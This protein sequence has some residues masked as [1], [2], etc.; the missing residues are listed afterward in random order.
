MISRHFKCIESFCVVFRVLGNVFRTFCINSNLSEVGFCFL[1]EL[2]HKADLLFRHR[3]R[4]VT[5]TCL[6]VALIDI[7]HTH[8]IL[9]SRTRQCSG[10][11]R[12]KLR[13][14]SSDEIGSFSVASHLNWECCWTLKHHR[15]WM[16]GEGKSKR[17]RPKH[18]AIDCM[19]TPTRRFDT[20]HSGCWI[21]ISLIDLLL[22]LPSLMYTRRRSW[23]H[24]VCRWWWWWWCRLCPTPLN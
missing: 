5:K 9:H 16:N 20:E 1:V 15:W 13:N 12:L 23:P 6:A 14:S 7:A 18:F 10:V 4:K 19:C 21:A 24:I 22:T 11:S 17:A 8:R 3:E 2:A